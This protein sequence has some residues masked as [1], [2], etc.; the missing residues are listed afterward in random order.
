MKKNH[1]NFIGECRS[2]RRSPYYSS[3]KHEKIVVHQLEYTDPCHPVK[4]YCLMIAISFSEVQCGVENTWQIGRS[5]G[6]RDDVNCGRNIDRNYFKAFA[7]A[8]PYCFSDKSRSALIKETNR[9]KF[10]FFV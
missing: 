3:V 7:S 2:S 5:N 10:F 9:R 4:T 8:S 1:A 6:L